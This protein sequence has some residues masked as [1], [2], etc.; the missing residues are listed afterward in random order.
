MQHTLNIFYNLSYF[1]ISVGQA[2]I[3]VI[4]FVVVVIIIIII[5]FMRT[6]LLVN[7]LIAV[8]LF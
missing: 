8:R 7:K 3:V 4:V 1:C 5:D 6:R 2:N